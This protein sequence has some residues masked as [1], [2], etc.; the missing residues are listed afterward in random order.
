MGV[1][2]IF[3]FQYG[4]TSTLDLVPF[5]LLGVLFTFQYGATSTEEQ[6]NKM[7]EGAKIYIPI[8]CYFYLTPYTAKSYYYKIYIPIWCYFY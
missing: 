8:W 4:A 6:A 5:P 1:G 7:I 2:I 3:T